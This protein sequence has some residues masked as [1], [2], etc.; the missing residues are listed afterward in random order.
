MATRFV[1]DV[2]SSMG[3]TRHAYIP[4][5]DD[6][7]SFA[8]RR[9]EISER[10]RRGSSGIGTGTGIVARGTAVAAAAAAKVPSSPAIPASKGTTATTEPT[11]GAHPSAASARSETATADESAAGGSCEAILS[12]FQHAALPVVVVELG[13]SV[14][15]IVSAF[16]GHHA[17]AFR[18]TIVTD[19]D[20]GADHAT[21]LGYTEES[22]ILYSFPKVEVLPG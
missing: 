6:R 14:A 20:V 4:N 1:S 7:A 15:S 10:I 3:N 19:V 18:T 13:N 2:A 22:V 21:M 11:S 17:R 5:I 9:G 12:D 8:S 16:K